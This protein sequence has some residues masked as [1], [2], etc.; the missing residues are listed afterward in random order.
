MISWSYLA[1]FWYNHKVW[2]TDRR[3]NRHLDDS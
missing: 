3:T 1:P 2:R